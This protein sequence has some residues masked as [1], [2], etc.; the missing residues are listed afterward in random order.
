[1]PSLRLTESGRIQ[2]NIGTMSCLGDT[3]IIMLERITWTGNL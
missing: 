2:L 3:I 1:M